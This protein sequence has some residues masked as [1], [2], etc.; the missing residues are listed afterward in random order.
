MTVSAT[1]SQVSG[2]LELREPARQAGDF[3]AAVATESVECALCG[4]SDFNPLFSAADYEYRLP[5]E[6]HVAQCRNCGLVAQNPRPP[7]SDILRYY[8]AQYTA[9]AGEDAGIVLRI[10]RAVLYRRRI[11]SYVE[12]IGRTGTILDIGCGDGSLLSA[13]RK[14]GEWELVGV[15]PSICES[16]AIP[17]IRIHATTLEGARL[18]D[19]SV[20]L[21]IMNH[22]LEHVPSPRKT[23]E[24]LM[25]ILRPGGYICGEVP[26]FNCVER[27]LFGK[28]WGGFHLP[29][30]ITHFDRRSLAGLLASCGLRNTV[31]QPAMQ[32][33]SW[34][35]SATNALSDRGWR[36]PGWIFGD[37]NV[38]WLSV[39]TPVAWLASKLGSAASISFV[40]QK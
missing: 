37:S 29:R 39:S 15:E 24:E 22:V 16:V 19:G 7:F 5:G 13:L 21:A 28:H 35:V 38:A 3:I 36:V 31:M 17:G 26:D 6:F 1:H 34:L 32:P 8:P 20:D 12:L 25:R 33:S 23:L 2:G 30:H 10:K 27:R 4:A 40:A 14:Q 18:A 11:G 9:L